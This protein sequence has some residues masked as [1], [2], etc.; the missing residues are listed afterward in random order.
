MSDSPRVGAAEYKLLEAAPSGTWVLRGG[1]LG[2][3]SREKNLRDVREAYSIWGICVAAEPGK[4]P[5]EIAAY[6]KFGNRQMTMAISD[7]LV[8]QGYLVVQEPGMNWPNALL[9]FN[10]QPDTDDWDRLRE[11]MMQRGLHPNPAYQGK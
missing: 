5:A 9:T 11:V 6:G 2:G 10:R 3:P 1:D 7:E 8:A 4:T